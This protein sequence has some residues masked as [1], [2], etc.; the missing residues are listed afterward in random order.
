[1]MPAAPPASAS[2]V[3]S[4]SNCRASRQRPAPSAARIANSLLRE[5]APR[6]L[7]IRDVR[8]GDQQHA[9]HR[10]EQQL[11]TVAIIT[12]GRFKQLHSV[13]AP[14]GVCVG[15]LLLERGGDRVEIGVRLRQSHARL[16]SAKRREPGMIPALQH[17]LLRAHIIQW[18]VDLRQARIANLRR[19]HTD[20]LARDTVDDHLPAENI[21]CTTKLALP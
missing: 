16:E 18:R 20:N 4:V 11:Q 13:D 9:K 8:A 14:R 1:M 2:K 5:T 10:R 3:L 19:Q 15:I 6:E 21:S 17:V 7:Q 12:D